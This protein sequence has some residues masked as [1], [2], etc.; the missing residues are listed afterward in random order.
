[1]E[2]TSL[3]CGQ[4]LPEL[5]SASGNIIPWQNEKVFIVKQYHIHDF[6][7]GI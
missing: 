2:G 1:M 3:Q 7:M 5:V 6:L 4:P